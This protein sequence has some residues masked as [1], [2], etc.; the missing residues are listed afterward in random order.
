MKKIFIFCGFL[1]ADPGILAKYFGHRED[2]EMMNLFKVC[3]LHLKSV[4][5]Y[6]SDWIFLFYNACFLLY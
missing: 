6:Q 3:T 5:Y 1:N 2:R 4:G